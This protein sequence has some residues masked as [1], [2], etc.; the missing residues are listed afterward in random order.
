MH[1]EELWE[2]FRKKDKKERELM[3]LRHEICTK[4]VRGERARNKHFFKQIE[5]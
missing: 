5:I 1:R 2:I 4:A 3:N